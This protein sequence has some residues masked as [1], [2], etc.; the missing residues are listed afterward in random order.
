MRHD[1]RRV[2]VLVDVLFLA[3]CFKVRGFAGVW[4]GLKGWRSGR[5]EE[6][7]SVGG[8]DKRAETA[9]RARQAA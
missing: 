5:S 6:G 9:G 4:K 7:V 2:Q 1:I 8:I 3:S